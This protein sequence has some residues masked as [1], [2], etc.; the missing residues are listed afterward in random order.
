MNRKSTWTAALVTLILIW[1]IGLS[2]I[3]AQD[4]TSAPL[5]SISADAE[6]VSAGQ[7]VNLTVRVSGA[8]N[9][10]GTSFKIAYDPSAFEV[11]ATD[12]KAVMPGAF[13][14]DEPGFALRNAADTSQGIIEYA[15]TLM[16]P[17]KPVTGDGVLGTVTLRALKDAPVAISVTQASF[18]S[19]EFTEVGGQLVAQKVNQIAAQIENSTLTVASA[20]ASASVGQVSAPVSS[21]DPNQAAMFNNPALQ[22]PA[23]ADHGHAAATTTDTTF[24]LRNDGLMMASAVVFFFVGIILLTVSVGMY[25]RMRTRLALPSDYTLANEYQ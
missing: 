24:T 23:Q 15:L 18:V 17:A 9:V 14:A 5:L 1:S 25:S 12:S 19:P 4:N 6:Q 13:F 10:Y 11:V 8:I 20:S 16:Q 22:S 2:A 7:S 3:G 21:A